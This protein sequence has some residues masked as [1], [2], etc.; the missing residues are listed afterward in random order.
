MNSCFVFLATTWSLSLDF[1]L[2][3]A[4]FPANSSTHSTVSFF[5]M[6]LGWNALP[7]F[8]NSSSLCYL[9]LLTSVGVNHQGT[10]SHC[11]SPGQAEGKRETFSCFPHIPTQARSWEALWFRLGWTTVRSPQMGLGPTQLWGLEVCAA[12]EEQHDPQLSCP[13]ASPLGWGCH[14]SSLRWVSRYQPKECCS[15]KP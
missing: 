14:L 4:E 3:E 15:P 12:G 5:L 8:L 13:R 7:H 11:D 6:D 2:S 10:S 9:E 1:P